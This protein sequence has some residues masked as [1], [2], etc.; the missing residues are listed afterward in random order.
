MKWI[1]IITLLIVWYLIGYKLALIHNEYK[2][3]INRTTN[4]KK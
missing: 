4:K 1:L 2:N 3:D